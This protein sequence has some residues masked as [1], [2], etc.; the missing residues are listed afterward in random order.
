MEVSKVVVDT[1]ED[2]VSSNLEPVADEPTSSSR[3]DVVA[4]MD[5]YVEWLL[6]PR[7]HRSPQTK[8]DLAAL[9]G[10]STETLRRYDHDP[11]VRREYLKRS[12]A[13]FTVSRAADIIDTLYKR[14]TDDHDPQG[15]T[16]AKTLMQYM[17]Q[18]DEAEGADRVDLSQLTTD[19]LVEL[20]LRVAG[21]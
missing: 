17:Q 18:Q 7:S 15:V 20:A 3:D 4:R 19:E 14:A 8:K 11:W 2:A 10:I 21:S 13:S 5:A 12:R 1:P 9:L 6:T 16:A